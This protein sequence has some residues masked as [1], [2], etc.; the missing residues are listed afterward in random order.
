MIAACFGQVSCWSL[1]FSK[2]GYSDKKKPTNLS[3]K[4]SLSGQVVV[5]F[6]AVTEDLALKTE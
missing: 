1:S 6:C 3:C 2:A 4:P 5:L